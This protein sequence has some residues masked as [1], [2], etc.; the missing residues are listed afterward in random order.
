MGRTDEAITIARSVIERDPDILYGHAQLTII[1]ADTGQDA[2]A[3]RAAAEVL[4]INPKFSVE[5]W[6]EG[7]GQGSE[8]AAREVDALR[9]AG[10]PE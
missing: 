3:R 8:V 10:L 2:E 9:K 5:A 1:L 6:S 7:R 4:R